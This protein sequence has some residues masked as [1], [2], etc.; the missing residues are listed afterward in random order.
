[1]E[2]LTDENLRNALHR[3]WR[4]VVEWIEYSRGP[5]IGL[6]GQKHFR[7]K[8]ADWQKQKKEWLVK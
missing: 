3:G 4:D 8:L 6:P 2:Q 5:A 1:M 7:I